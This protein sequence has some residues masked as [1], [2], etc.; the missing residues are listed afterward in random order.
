[1]S[2]ALARRLAAA[3]VLAAFAHGSAAAA[4]LFLDGS[5]GA[6]LP[7][8]GFADERGAD[9][10]AGWQ[11]AGALE[12]PLNPRW[13]L[14]LD[15]AW[16]Q[17]GQGRVGQTL[18][19]GGGA[20]YTLEEDTFQTWQAGAHARWWMAPGHAVQPYALLGFGV[21]STSEDYTESV[22]SPGAVSRTSVQGEGDPR[23]GGRLGL[24]AAWM[25]TPGFGFGAE[26]S[27]NLV[28]MDEERAGFST[29]RCL[30]LGAGLR[31]ALPGT[32]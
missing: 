15:A 2:R 32:R 17:H 13:S 6:S 29:L 5:A 26:A 3:V 27:L 4:T 22:T 24:G 18:D 31:V 8:G 20:V 10:Q 1:M 12:I 21:Y 25:L 23:P 9:A 30:G 16:S 14:G 11:V 19:L 7:S 28:A